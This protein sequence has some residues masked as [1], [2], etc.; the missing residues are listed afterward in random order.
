MLVD[1][2]CLLTSTLSLFMRAE[3]NWMSRS[4]LASLLCSS[5]RL[6]T[7]LADNSCLLTSTMSLLNL[8]QY[9]KSVE[10]SSM[11]QTPVHLRP[12]SMPVTHPGVLRMLM[13]GRVGGWGRRG[14]GVAVA[15]VVEDIACCPV[16]YPPPPTASTALYVS[17]A[18]WV[19]EDC[20]RVFY[21]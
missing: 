1:N 18:V 8:A 14:G 19:M 9:S 16:F 10:E 7:M 6:L 12:A 2:S 3:E 15:V 13:P 5:C 20:G 4:L 21:G 11:F 17:P